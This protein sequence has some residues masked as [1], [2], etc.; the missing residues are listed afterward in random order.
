M[1]DENLQPG[2][3]IPPKFNLYIFLLCTMFTQWSEQT[4]SLVSD[5]RK[6]FLELL[7]QLLR[8]VM[9]GKVLERFLLKK[10]G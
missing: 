3:K 2:K 5:E 6:V 4:P 8:V 9:V 1:Y 7:E 10:S